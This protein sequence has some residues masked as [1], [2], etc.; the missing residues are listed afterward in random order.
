MTQFRT[1]LA[2]ALLASSL[3]ASPAQAQFGGLVGKAKAAA[4]LGGSDSG[5]APAMSGD[6]AD[7]FLQS[8]L[9]ST[10]NVL[11]ASMIIAKALD[12]RAPLTAHKAELDSYNSISSFKEFNAHKGSLATNFAAIGNRKDVAADFEARYNSAS[13]AEKKILGIASVNL[14]IGIARNIDLAG[15]LPGVLDAVKR[16]PQ[17]ITRVGQFKAAAELIGMQGKG[18]SSIATQV[19]KLMTAAKVRA[20]KDPKN[21]E[22]QAIAL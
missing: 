11:I 20:P 2:A 13:A 15:Q 17:L 18:L 22:D 10:K 1:H 4:G 5:S 8:S 12:D 14:A 6:E 16:N 7:R 9:R 19:P 3:L 21:S